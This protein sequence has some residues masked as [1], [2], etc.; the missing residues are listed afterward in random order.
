MENVVES[1]DGI[2][3]LAN[4]MGGWVVSSSIESKDEGESIATISIRVPAERFDETIKALR[5]LA[6]E[7]THE[8]SDSKDVTEEYVDLESELRNLEATESQYLELMKRAD[9]VDEVLKV[10]AKLSEVRSRI[11][12]TEGR[13]QYLERSSATSIIEIHLKQVK[14]LVEPGWSASRIAKS[15]VHGLATAG[16]VI[17]QIGIWVGIFTPIWLP[18]VLVIYWLRR[19]KAKAR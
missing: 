19:R 11:E 6:V 10:Q 9:A 15:A 13:M 3:D 18:I 16:Q 5:D 4:E 8:S 17:G 1:V 7:V 14:P 12:Q 2:A